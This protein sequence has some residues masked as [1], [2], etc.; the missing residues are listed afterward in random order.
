MSSQALPK[1]DEAPAGCNSCGGQASL[2][3]ITGIGMRLVAVGISVCSRSVGIRTPNHC[4]SQITNGFWNAFDED[5]SL[6]RQFHRTK[7]C[8]ARYRR[9]AAGLCSTLINQTE[10]FRSFENSLSSGHIGKAL[11]NS[12]TIR[13]SGELSSLFD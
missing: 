11:D 9:T 1:A 7:P 12:A 2:A 6:L 4:S 3:E 10:R 13:I 8:T 5:D